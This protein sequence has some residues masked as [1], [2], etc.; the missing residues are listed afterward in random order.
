VKSHKDFAIHTPRRCT[1]D[2]PTTKQRSQQGSKRQTSTSTV[3][4]KPVVDQ[5]HLSLA[6]LVKKPKEN[7]LLKEAVDHVLD[8]ITG[9]LAQGYS[10][11]KLV[12]VMQKN[13]FNV[14]LALLQQASTPATETAKTSPAGRTSTSRGGRAKTNSRTT[15][16]KAPT[17]RS[18]SVAKSRTTASTTSA[19]SRAK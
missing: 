12:E 19:R 17:Q 13:G 5:A 2:M 1:I 16:E 11:E 9:A 14:N 10:H 3:V 4:P 7:A 6:E 15:T 8:V 18:R